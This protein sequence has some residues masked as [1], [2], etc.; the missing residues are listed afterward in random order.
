VVQQALDKASKG[1][2]T[3]A[4]AHRLSTIRNADNIVVMAKGRIVE[5]GTHDELMQ[6][7]GVYRS[8]VQAQELGSKIVP[9][10]RF[11]EMSLTEKGE[12]NL[13][14]AEKLDLVRTTTTKPA[15][16]HAKG[17]EEKLTYTTWGLMK[18][19]WQMNKGEHM[20]MLAGF[21]CSI[22][23]GANPAMQAI[24]LGNAI[25]SFFLPGTSLGGHDVKF[26][27]W[28]F[29]MLGFATWLFYFFQ[30]LTLA[31]ASAYAKLR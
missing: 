24:F 4:I 15:S 27:C 1:R 26:W 13:A 8:L 30:G 7:N 25:N 21:L 29:F 3:I 10:N 17:S 22:L 23:A 2:T 11:S 19:S 28:M 5:Q 12:P 14:E 9:N 6:A 18:F 16:I 20:L 31:R